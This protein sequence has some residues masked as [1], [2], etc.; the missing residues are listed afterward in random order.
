MIEV[1]CLVD[2]DIEV[3]LW[4]FAFVCDDGISF[5]YGECGE[6]IDEESGKVNILVEVGCCYFIEEKGVKGRFSLL[7][8]LLELVHPVH[9]YIHF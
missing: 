8:E 4:L 2:I 1:P 9:Y 3:A 5:C 7:L 6:L